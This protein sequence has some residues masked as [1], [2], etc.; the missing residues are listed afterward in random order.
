MLIKL[1]SIC[2]SITW[3]KIPTELASF[4]FEKAHAL[5]LTSFYCLYSYRRTIATRTN[6]RARILTIIYKKK[7]GSHG[8]TVT[9]DF[10]SHQVEE[11][12]YLY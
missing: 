5:H 2:F 7:N 6:Q 12:A 9:Y 1:R 4:F 3:K 8:F 10:F 11:L